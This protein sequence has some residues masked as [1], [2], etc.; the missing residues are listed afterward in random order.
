MRG[1]ISDFFFFF[2]LRKTKHE[3]ERAK[4]ILEIFD[5]VSERNS[6]GGR[7]K[8]FLRTR[9]EGEVEGLLRGYKRSG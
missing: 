3:A 7:G 8:H 4:V 9:G 2:F 6:P 1:G 5:K